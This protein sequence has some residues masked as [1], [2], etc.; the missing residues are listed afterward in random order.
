[1]TGAD[2]LGKE[3][4]DADTERIRFLTFALNDGRFQRDTYKTNTEID[5]RTRTIFHTFARTLRGRGSL[6]KSTKDAEMRQLLMI[7]RNDVVYPLLHATAEVAN[8]QATFDRW[9]ADA[10]QVVKSKCPIQWDRGTSLTV[11]H[12]QKI[13]NLHCKSLWALEL[14]PESCSVYFHATIDNFML[15]L[16]K[17]R[18]GWS[19][20]DSYDRYLAYQHQLRQIAQTYDSYPLVVE[21]RYWYNNSNMTKNHRKGARSWM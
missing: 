9:H 15:E 5:R 14:I 17:E 21:C 19:R 16:L 11:G 1:M 8:S 12:A 18:A 6:P 10:V 13:I 2:L 20:C 7:I 4:L 3:S